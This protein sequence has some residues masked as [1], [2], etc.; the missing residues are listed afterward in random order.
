MCV[1]AT[2]P[3]GIDLIFKYSISVFKKVENPMDALR[4]SPNPLHKCTH[5]VC[6]LFAFVENSYGA[7]WLA[8]LFGC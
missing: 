6:C 1:F 8:C 5:F 4:V 2:G 3:S 7:Q